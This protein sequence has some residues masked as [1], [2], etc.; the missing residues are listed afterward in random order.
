MSRYDQL[1]AEA[2]AFHQKHPE[3]W[4]LFEKFTFELIRR[5]FQH[6]SARGIWHRIRWETATPDPVDPADFKLNDHHTP[7]YAR[8]FMLR[9]PNY[10]GFFRIRTQIS[11]GGPKVHLPPLKPANFPYI[12]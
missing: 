6:Y 9:Y 7:F 11:Q 5:G 1:F 8:A 10:D 4:D 3:V 12:P 2:N